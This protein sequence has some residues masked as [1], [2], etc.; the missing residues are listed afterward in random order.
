MKGLQVCN[1][2]DLQY[3]NAGTSSDGRIHQHALTCA[4]ELLSE[5]KS[6]TGLKGAVRALGPSGQTSARHP[7]GGTAVAAAHACV[8]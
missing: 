4:D 7:G 1:S 5:S 8:C 2:T 3:L 6:D